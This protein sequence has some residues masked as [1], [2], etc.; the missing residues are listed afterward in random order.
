MK[1]KAAVFMGAQKPFEVREFEVTETPRGYARMELIASGVCGT[2]VHI[3]NGVLACGAPSVIGHEFV[4]KITDMDPEEGAKYGLQ[5]GDNVIADIAVP[6]GECPLCKAGDDAN[7]V[8]MQVTN[9]GSI[10]VA[11][12][13]YGGYAEVNYTPLT[14]LIKIPASVDPTVATIFA[15]PGPTSIHGFRL[16]ERAGGN[17]S[18]VKVAVVQGLGPVGMF[19]VMYLAALGVPKVYAIVSGDDP[20]R[21]N[22]A[23]SIG[24]TKI[25]SLKRDGVE[26]ITAALQ[27]ENDG[28]GVDLCVEASGAPSAVAQGIDI[29]R[30][31]GVYLVPGQYS[32]SGSVTIQ[33]QLITFKA[34]HIIGS[35]QYALC[36]VRDYLAFLEAHPEL[37]SAIAKMGTKYAVADVNNAFADAKKRCNIKTLL[38][39]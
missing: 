8:H 14:N 36:D 31:R 39:K 26:Q 33:P 9:S 12:Y 25:F 20:V 30:N 34:L 32:H 1:A 27:S 19:S 13:L 22:A 3:H 18:D 7:C 24:A 11:P 23:R 37:E 15:C 21:E 28:L 2:D 16:A 4:G 6:C 5:I 29:L 17:L 10:E 38:V 35:S